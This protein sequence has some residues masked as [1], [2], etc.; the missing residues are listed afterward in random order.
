MMT[1]AA[2]GIS[3]NCLEHNTDAREYWEGNKSS[4]IWSMKAVITPYV[5]KKREK[6]NQWLSHKKCDVDVKRADI[7]NRESSDFSSV[8]TNQ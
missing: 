4:Q 1:D 3:T 5:K 6:E 8:L 2:F 7:S